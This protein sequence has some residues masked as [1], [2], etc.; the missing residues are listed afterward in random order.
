M[1]L[2]YFCN[3]TNLEHRRDYLDVL[4]DVREVAAFCEQAGFHCI[5]FAE[6]HFS[7]WGREML[8]NPILM[9]TD[10]AARTSRIRIGLAAAIITFWHPLRLAEDVALLDQLSGG[11]LELGLGRGNYGIEALNLN[12]LADP[13]HPEENRAV[14]EETL[15]VMRAAFAGKRFRFE[16]RKYVFP[17]PGFRT[18]RA[19]TVR[20][21][22]YVDE[23][24]GELVRLSVYPRP[25]QSPLPMWQM[26]DSESSIR[27]AA[28]NDLG[29]ILWRPPVSALAK[30]F[31]L[32]RDSAVAAG[33][34]PAGQPVGARCGILRDMFVAES[35]AEARRLAAEPVM[36]TL[37]FS[38][39]RGPDI[40]L[41][42]GETLSE[43]RRAALESRLDF[44]FVK[45]RAL[46]FGTPEQ[47]AKRLAE[48]RDDLG[49][50][51]V[52]LNCHWPGLSHEH[53]LRSLALFRDEVMPRLGAAS[54]DHGGEAHTPAPRRIS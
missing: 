11:R 46:L 15:A 52:L 22:D 42:P 5:W 30:R 19:H 44:D 51:Q 28:E 45:D 39:W 36:S 14:F 43:S 31:E 26:V 4:E 20:L 50:E 53:T 17:N 24:T 34:A 47:V 27:F 25:R 54:A 37:N 12:P 38:N 33:M 10:V 9:G 29:V 6:H 49:V 3:P 1:H 32:Y 13:N 48:L 16:G 7:L 21:P 35:E 18:D 41:E 2:S 40:Y 8:P 23:A